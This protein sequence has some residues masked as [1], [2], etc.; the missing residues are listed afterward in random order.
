LNHS[1]I[2]EDDKYVTLSI[3]PIAIKAIRAALKEIVDAKG[4]GEAQQRVKNLAK[5]LLFDFL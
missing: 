5:W 4:D 3:L 1:K 2:L